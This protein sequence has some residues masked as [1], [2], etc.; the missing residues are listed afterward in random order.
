MK[1]IKNTDKMIREMNILVDVRKQNINKPFTKRKVQIAKKYVKM[2]HT[3]M[4]KEI[5]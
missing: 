1:F 4:I 5:Q 3:Q 2:S